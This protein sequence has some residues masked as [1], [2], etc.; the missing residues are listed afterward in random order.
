MLALRERDLSEA[1]QSLFKAFEMAVSVPAL[2]AVVGPEPKVVN[3][4]TRMALAASDIYHRFGQEYAQFP[5]SQSL[6]LMKVVLAAWIIIPNTHFVVI[7]AH[8]QTSYALWSS[9]RYRCRLSELCVTCCFWSL[10]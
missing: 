3:A 6:M 7:S 2:D 10:D 9:H 1:E 5:C 4:W 8:G